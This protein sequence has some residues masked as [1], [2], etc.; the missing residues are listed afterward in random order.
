M[1]RTNGGRFERFKN[2]IFEIVAEKK[3]DSLKILGVDDFAV[4]FLVFFYR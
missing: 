3:F 1:K 4:S 2:I